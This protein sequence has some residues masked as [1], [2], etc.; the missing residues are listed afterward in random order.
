MSR[1]K[2]HQT[3]SLNSRI[4]YESV[5]DTSSS[6]SFQQIKHVVSTS[7]KLIHESNFNVFLDLFEEQQENANDF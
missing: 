4:N 2:F 6:V 3:Q 1:N 5:P 7:Q